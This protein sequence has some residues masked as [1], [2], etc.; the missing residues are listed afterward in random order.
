MKISVVGLGKLGASMAAAMASRGYSVIGVDTDEAKVERLNAGRAPAR[1]PGLAEVVEANED[2]LRATSDGKAAARA[3]DV[4][5]LVVPTPSEPDGSFS[6]RY[7][8]DACRKLGA[9]LREATDY[10]TVVVTSTV[11][12]GATEKELLPVLEEASGKRVGDDFGL[13]YSPEF[14]ALGSVIEDFLHPDFTLIGEYDRRSGDGLEGLYEDLHGSA[15]PRHRMS[16]VNAELAKVALNTFVTTK[17]S[18]ANMLADICERMPG[19]DV[20]AVTDAVGEDRRV[21]HAYLTG[22]LG[23][24]GPCFPRDNKALSHF[25]RTVGADGRLCE[26]VDAFNRRVPARAFEC[27]ER[28]LAPGRRVAVLGL[29]YKPGSHVVEESQ[30][31]QM[32]NAAVA[33]GCEVAAYDPEVDDFEASGLASGATLAKSIDACLAGAEVVI[34]ATRD[35][36]FGSL[37]P[38]DFEA[39]EDRIVVVDFWR[40]LDED[41]REAPGIDYVPYGSSLQDAATGVRGGSQG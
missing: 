18:F 26:A 5:F 12:P 22:A 24:G 30:A 4:S 39:G 20:D 38:G 41:L 31:V 3:T 34:V 2:R 19:G 29:S 37:E 33:S 16:L 15:V 11:L 27:I 7:L 1:E 32:A 21:G 10:H 6:V 9:G 13:C 23:Y 36:A 8:V 40:L 35:P 25:A 17:I 28:W 14:I